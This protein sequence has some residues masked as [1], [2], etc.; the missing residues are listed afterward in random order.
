MTDFPSLSYTLPSENPALSY[1]G[2]LKKVSPLSWGI[3][4]IGHYSE[5]P[6]GRNLSSS[7]LHQMCFD[8]EA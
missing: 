6:S 7:D 5:K 1:N 4:V 3:I 2:S 8:E